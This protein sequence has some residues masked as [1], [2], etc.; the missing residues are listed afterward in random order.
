M[1]Q[2][3]NKLRQEI[4]EHNYRYYV[5]DQP[6]IPDAEYDRLF[7]ALQDLEQAHPELVTAD[8]PTQRIGGAP[9]PEFITVTHEVPMLSL[10]NAYTADEVLAFDKRIRQR[11][12]T[13]DAIEYAS[14]PKVDGVAVSLMY[15]EGLYVRAATRGDGMQG[16]D[17]T[18]NV[19]TISA[20][21]LHLRGKGYP[22][23]L[24]VRGEI[25]MPLKDFAQFNEKARQKGEREFVNPR[26]AAAGS[27]RQLDPKITA[28]RPLSLFCYAIGKVTSGELPDKHS[29]M[30]QQLKTWGFPV[31]PDIAVQE[32]IQGCLTFYTK[33][34]E[35][36]EQ[37]PYEIDGV[38]YKVNVF[39]LQNALGFVSR[40]PRWALAHKFA[41]REAMT[42]VEA[43]AF[44]VGR[45]G[46]L[47]PV[48]RL[49]P[50]FVS[51]VTVS[52]A[53]LHNV[54]EMWRKDVRVGDTVIVKRAGD[55]IPDIVAVVMEK[56]PHVTEPVALPAHCPICGAEVIKPEGEVIARCTGG[57][58][59]PAQ[60]KE[61]IKH[62]A[63]RRALDI[64]GLGEKIVEQLVAAHLV[65]DI[66]GIYQL[67]PEQLLTLER[68]GEKS[69]ENLLAAIATS[70]STT[71]QR[72]LYGLGIRDVGEATALNLAQ[73]FGQLNPLLT[74]DEA[75]LQE[76]ADI[77]PI[78]AANI[79]GFF[80]Q[81]HNQ[82]LIIKLQQLGVHWQEQAPHA[83]T[84]ARP[85]E[86]KIFVLT[87]TLETLTRDA[88]KEKLQ[89]L[90]AKVAGSVSS[91]TSY[92]VAGKDP[93][94]K[95]AK[96]ESLG[97]KILSE[98]A[99]LELLQ[100]L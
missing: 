46:A 98:A 32:D 93:G 23:V 39:A 34:A 37:L 97:V 60:L 62:F 49:H 66:A 12:K 50:V 69:V 84:P 65:T 9:L 17:I 95:L 89:S 21:P 15:E 78:V 31:N 27:L 99:F 52:N 43:I 58:F 88:A 26:N 16:E 61:T 40:A 35:K 86:K 11:L 7:K 4:E 47:T 67:T 45:T 96:A 24:E 54:E 77:G 57:L 92:V 20:V 79:A 42:Q 36:R 38:V 1:Q 53:T 55:V 94:S 56:R 48:A 8:S 5:L 100:A 71:L 30:L 73:H 75:D 41:A 51:G 74:A 3:I 22:R 70:Q 44:Q 83:K 90:G 64:E 76:I 33:M 10:E 85:L 29:A 19:R 28:Q 13:T 91:K 2:Q 59:C 82:E 80:R 25:Y 14:E 87:G 6:T 72:F 81:P 68:M 63:S 18:Q